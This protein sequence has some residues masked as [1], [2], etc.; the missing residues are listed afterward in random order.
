MSSIT[1]LIALGQVAEPASRTPLVII[2][3]YM[4]VLF[5]LGWISS[6]LF[7][8]SSKD[9][10]VASHSIGPFM[11]LMSV[12][13]TTM[14]AFALVGSTGKAFSLGI[15]VYGLMASSSGLIHAACFFLVGIRMWSFGK[16]YGYVTQIQFFRDRF[17]SK[18][19]GYLLFPILAGLI[20]PY[21]LVGLIGAG[22]YI[23][24]VRRRRSAG[25]ADRLGDLWGRPVLRLLRRGAIRR[26]GE[27][28]PDDCVH[29]H[30]PRRLHRD[31]QGHRRLDR[32]LRIG[33]ETRPG[34]T[35]P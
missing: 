6:R 8:G 9:F 25:L 13:G 5:G 3:I 29:D 33:R 34:E 27:H 28:V 11:L 22:T 21:L 31:R 15:G 1:P 30:G 14:T 10:F 19:L 17:E 7:R 24:D 32:G 16:K 35:R 4:C 20:I 26:L 18:K 2:G 12:F 23:G